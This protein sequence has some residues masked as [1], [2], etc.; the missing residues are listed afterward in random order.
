V[1]PLRPGGTVESSPAGTAGLQLLSE[2]VP[3]GRLK[4]GLHADAASD[5]PDDR[6][7]R[8]IDIKRPSGTQTHLTTTPAGTA[9]LLSSVPPGQRGSTVS[10]HM[11][12]LMLTHRGG[13]R[14]RGDYAFVYQNGHM[15]KLGEYQGHHIFRATCINNRGQ[16]VAW[17]QGATEWRTLLYS[18][19]QMQD[20]PALAALTVQGTA[21][22][23]K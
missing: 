6:N 8:R 21:I 20:I 12:L 23:G 22:N 16:I 17:Y 9:G 11:D 2:R 13:R 14:T 1:Q 7:L 3:E 18:G 4:P 19:G 10:Q 15:S 5:A